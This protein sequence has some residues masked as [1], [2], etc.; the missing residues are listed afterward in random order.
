MSATIIS[1]DPCVC[2]SS[3]KTHQSTRLVRANSS[4]VTHSLARPKN[5]HKVILLEHLCRGKRQSQRDG[6]R[7]TLWHGDNDDGDGNNQDVHKRRRLLRREAVVAG[8]FGN[9]A[10]QEDKEE[11]TGGSASEVRDGAGEL[12]EL[13]LQGCLFGLGADRHHDLAVAAVDTDR[14]A[15]ECADACI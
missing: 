13:L 12:G 4:R 6:K 15:E 8:E 9:E 1:I 5:S 7:Q 11:E 3:D 2:D 10:E 14:G